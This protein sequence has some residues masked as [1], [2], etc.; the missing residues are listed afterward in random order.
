MCLQCGQLERERDIRGGEGE[1]LP[2]DVSDCISSS[3]TVLNGRAIGGDGE[4][5]THLYS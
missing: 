2:A 5:I 1:R 4:I 3:V